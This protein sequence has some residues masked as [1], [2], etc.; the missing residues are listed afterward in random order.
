MSVI[1]ILGLRLCSGL[2]LLV[3]LLLVDRITHK[4]DKCIFERE[5]V[6]AETY[7]RL[8]YILKVNWN[9]VTVVVT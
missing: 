7:S 9:S 1:V 6:E 2:G 3:C 8:S 4:D 5:N